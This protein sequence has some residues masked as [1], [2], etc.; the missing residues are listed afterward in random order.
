MVNL[1]FKEAARGVN[2]DV[3]IS[4]SDTCPKCN[5]HRCRPGSKPVKCSFCNGTGMVCF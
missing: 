3:L 1:S 5:G 2:K 4:V